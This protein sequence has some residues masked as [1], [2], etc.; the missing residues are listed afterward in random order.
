M[1]LGALKPATYGRLSSAGLVHVDFR[2][3]RYDWQLNTV[4]IEFTSCGV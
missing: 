3:S 2:Q 1:S 4:L